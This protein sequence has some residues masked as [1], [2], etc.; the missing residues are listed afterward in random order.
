MVM[1]RGGEPLT[2]RLNAVGAVGADTE[3]VT[4][5]RTVSTS[6]VVGVPD[7]TP[8]AAFIDSQ[9]PVSGVT[10]ARFHVYG[11][12]PF[13][14]DMVKLYATPTVPFGRETVVI[15]GGGVPPVRGSIWGTIQLRT[16]VIVH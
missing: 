10:P 4:C 9:L 15:S 3:S 14:A 12:T 5:I 11:G 8:V 2:V 7:N 16:I 6:P 13:V 1:S